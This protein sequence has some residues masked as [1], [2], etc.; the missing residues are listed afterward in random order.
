MYIL[1][2]LH[3][4]SRASPIRPA[5]GRFPVFSTSVKIIGARGSSKTVG[6]EIELTHTGMI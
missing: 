2:I 6:R 3:M 5:F 4:K 1:N